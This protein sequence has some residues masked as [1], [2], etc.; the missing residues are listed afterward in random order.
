MRQTKTRAQYQKLYNEKSE[1][2]RTIMD[3]QHANFNDTPAV[4][5]R[6]AHTIDT[7]LVQLKAALDA[8]DKVED[9]DSTLPPVEDRRAEANSEQRLHVMVATVQA[10]VAEFLSLRKRV[11]EGFEEMRGLIAR[12]SLLTFATVAGLIALVVL[13]IVGVL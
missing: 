6:E 7:E 5:V 2:L 4:L 9:L 1:R 12:N 13:L 8:L 10:T 11:D 3:L